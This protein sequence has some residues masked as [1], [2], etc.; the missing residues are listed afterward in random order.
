M[1]PVDERGHEYLTAAERAGFLEAARC[2]GP[3]DQTSGLTSPA[4][5]QVFNIPGWSQSFNPFS[6]L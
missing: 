2:A 1:V 6:A 4:P 5:G 3:V